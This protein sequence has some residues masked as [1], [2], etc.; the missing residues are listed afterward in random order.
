[1]KPF[2]VL[3]SS[4]VVGAIGWKGEARR[5]LRLLARRGFI[6]VRSPWLTAE[7][8][9]ATE[10][11]S[12]QSRSWANP[13]WAE[14]L[15]WLSRVSILIEDPP[16]RRTVRDPKDDPVLMAAIAGRASFLVTTDRDLLDLEKPYG[17]HILP[18]TRFLVE[19][20]RHQTGG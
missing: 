3:D 10:R 11:V 12:K 2:V 6:S 9:D 16:L 14:W 17:V 5:V 1:V 19:L 15:G 8:V 20:L 13:N 7:W 4:T 18:P